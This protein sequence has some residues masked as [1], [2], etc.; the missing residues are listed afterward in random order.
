MFDFKVGQKYKTRNGDVAIIQGTL[1]G[2]VYVASGEIH[3][4]IQT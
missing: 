4:R 1:L 3:Q 2:R